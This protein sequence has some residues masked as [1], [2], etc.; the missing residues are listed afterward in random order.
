MSAK[1]EGT[2]PLA[3]ERVISPAQL[4]LCMSYVEVYS[5]TVHYWGLNVKLKL[6]KYEHI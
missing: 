3:K 1:A 5:V 2:T 4:L 6:D